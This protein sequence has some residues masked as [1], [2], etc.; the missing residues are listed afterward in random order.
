[1]MCAEIDSECS[2]PFPC[3]IRTHVTSSITVL[4]RVHVG[5]FKHSKGF[6]MTYFANNADDYHFTDVFGDPA[7]G[8]HILDKGNTCS[9]RDSLNFALAYRPRTNAVRGYCFQNGE[10]VQN[11]NCVCGDKHSP[12]FNNCGGHCGS[13]EGNWRRYTGKRASVCRI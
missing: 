12:A 1:M 9:E 6:I 5:V 11:N 13:H 10:I 8:V 7:N 2:R 3:Y 4:L